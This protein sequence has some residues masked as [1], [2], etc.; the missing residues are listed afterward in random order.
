MGAKQTTEQ[1]TEILNDTQV[2]NAVAVANENI[3]DMTMN[4]MQSLMQSTAAGATLTQD[5]T[6]SN[7]TAAGDIE[8]SDVSQEASATISV[9]SLV[10]SE[11]K[12]ELVNNTMSE[13]QTKLEESM[14]LNQESANAS[15][16]QWVSELVGALSGAI[17][18]VTGTSMD[19]ITDTN[20]QNLLNIESETEL[21]NT[22]SQAVSSELIT[23]TVNQVANTVVGAQTLEISNIESETG[24][25]VVSNVSQSILSQQMLTAINNAGTGIDI[26]ASMSNV[27][28]TEM[29]TAV[30]AGQAGAT[31]EQGTVDAVSGLADTALSGITDL[32]STAALTVLIPILIVL[33][34]GFVL[35]RGVISAVGAK[36]GGVDAQEYQM[37]QQPM[38]TGGGS[39]LYKRIMKYIKKMF[40]SFC[41]IVKK[42]F[43]KFKKYLT[44]RN[45]LIAV[46]VIAVLYLGFYLYYTRGRKLEGFTTE[47]M[48]EGLKIS[49]DGKYVKNKALGNN[50]LVIT[51][52]ADDAFKFDVS[53]VN[54]K[55]LYLIREF[56]G[57]QYYVANKDDKLALEKY[58]KT[59]DSKY[60]F[61]FEVVSTGV[62][63]LIQGDKYVAKT[64]GGDLIFTTT[65]AD[66]IALKF[67]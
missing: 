2:R 26:M 45:I 39:K 29:T 18:A 47:S 35:F 20:I 1:R 10:N 5:L 28:T 16:E 65:A 13:L 53:L 9:S 19:N 25:I 56:N 6:I 49:S 63:N 61:T 14:Q 40:G 36:Q 23:E 24:S 12:Q 17:G 30:D 57:T 27:D 44:K 38:M 31:E 33:V 21:K 15:G 48:L 59:N 52:S 67:N 64:T 55:E 3:S 62:Y 51:A 34:I 60:K 41:K 37:Y 11:L 43:K 8:I 42:Y 7:L 54:E 22:I 4:I 58:D 32:T 46:A 66:K 50:E